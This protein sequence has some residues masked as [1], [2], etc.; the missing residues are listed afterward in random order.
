ME[1]NIKQEMGWWR[2]ELKRQTYNYSQSN[3]T[4]LKRDAARVA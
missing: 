2:E 4:R 3:K 1:Q